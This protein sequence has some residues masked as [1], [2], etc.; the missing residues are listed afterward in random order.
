[1][2]TDDEARENLAEN[3]ST[4]LELRGLTQTSLAEAINTPVM[5]LNHA[6]KG[7]RRPPAAL[8]ENLGEVLGYSSKELLGPPAVI[9]AR[10]QLRAIEKNR[11]E[12]L[13]IPA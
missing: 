3:L 11:R 4:I 13:L 7:R 6:V 8:V 12:N 2:I 5:T 9:V 1:M 10:E